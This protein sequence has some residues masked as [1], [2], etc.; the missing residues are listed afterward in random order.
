MIS[1]LILHSLGLNGVQ[2]GLGPAPKPCNSR[3]TLDVKNN[4]VICELADLQQ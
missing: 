3:E 4:L 1:T 2:H